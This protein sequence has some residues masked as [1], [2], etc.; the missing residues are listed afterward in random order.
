MN[1]QLYRLIAKADGKV[2]EIVEDIEGRDIADFHFSLI[3]TYFGI[4]VAESFSIEIEIMIE[5]TDELE[6]FLKPNGYYGI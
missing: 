5:D 4:R 6:A 1:T 2:I 3:R